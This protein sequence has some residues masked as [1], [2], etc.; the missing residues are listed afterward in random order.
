MASEAEIERLYQLF[1]T[2]GGG[3]LSFD[4]TNLTPKQYTD[5]VS[6]SNLTPLEMAQLEARQHQYNRQ[7]ALNSIA[8][9]IEANNFSN[10]YATRGAYGNSLFSALGSSP[11][12]TQVG[13]LNNAFSG[14]SSAEMATI[15]AGVLSQTGVDLEKILKIAGLSA[16]GI[17]M[18]TSL[19]NHTNNQTANIPSTLQDV[20]SLASMNEQFGEQGDPCSFFNQLMGLLAGIY[21]GTLDFIDNV[22]GDIT[23]LLN[24]TG[25]TSLFQAII[26]AVVGAGSVVADVI[27]A[28]VGVG[29]GA[30]GVLG[31]LVGQVINAIGD[32]TNAIANEINNMAD[33]AGQLLK[34]A[35]A[36]ILGEAALDPC[37]RE[38]LKNTGTTVMKEAVTQL[39]QPLGT[40][41]PHIVGTTID[42]RADAEEVKREMKYS[43]D[44]AKLNPGVPQSYD[45]DAAKKYVPNDSGEDSSIHT[46]IYSNSYTIH[47]TQVTATEYKDYKNFSMGKMTSE[48]EVAYRAKFDDSALSKNTI[49]SLK[50]LV[51]SPLFYEAQSK[52]IPK[53]KAYIQSQGTLM[54]DLNRKILVGIFETKEQ[55]AIKNRLEALK[56]ELGRNFSVVKNFFTNMRAGSK[57][58][59]FRYY[60]KDGKV[61]KNSE[62]IIKHNWRVVGEPEVQ[63]KYDSAL[64]NLAE[65]KIAWESMKDNIYD[66]TER[67][68]WWNSTQG[69]SVGIT[70]DPGDF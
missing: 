8:N 29:I 51:T 61:D 35:L 63:R 62:D 1:V 52:W 23:T 48:E 39:N 42:N 33:M 50:S 47:G 27:T 3:S 44:E 56:K 16:L 26:A 20:S 6:A 54:T 45:T 55:I 13:L 37:K 53:Q 14:F 24:D 60:S 7:A 64:K 32:I 67:V 36:L 38:V 43:R 70:S 10:P 2:N 69:I 31:S 12:A 19:T 59:N 34:K 30:L 22:I 49:S 65:T 58:K 57:N 11:G 66:D 18:Y 17:G 25:I 41:H 28:I 4:G 68:E 46:K 9:E 15:F 21:D 5:A 40:G